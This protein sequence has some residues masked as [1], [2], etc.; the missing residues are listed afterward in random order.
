MTSVNTAEIRDRRPLRFK[1]IDEVLADIDRIVAA[2]T[3]GKLR[4]TGNWTAGQVF[5]HVAAWINYAYEGYPMKPPPFFIRWILRAKKGTYLRAGMPSGVRIPGV[6]N[7]TF[8]LDPLDTKEG[9][10][11]LRRA[12]KRLQSGEANKFD[13][14]A[15]GRMSVDD[16]IA[17]NLRHAELHMSFLHP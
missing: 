6:A 10:D 14:P 12:L 5:G 16:R 2:D 11:R 4:R 15:F 8:A 9:A 1:S 7:G 17:L 3:A 13:S